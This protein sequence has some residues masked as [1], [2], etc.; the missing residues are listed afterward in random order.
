MQ[1]PQTLQQ[2]DSAGWHDDPID[3]ADGRHATSAGWTLKYVLR[4]PV[5]LDIVAAPD[6]AGW[7]SALTAVA[8]T[9]TPGL[10]GWVALLSNAGGERITVGNG[11]IT[12]NADLSTV[13]AGYDTRSTA[14]RALSDAESALA[15][16]KGSGGKIKKYEIAGRSMEFFAVA[17]ILQV[18]SYWKARVISEQNDESIANGQGDQRRL[19]VRFR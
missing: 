8:N 19:Y 5:A 3:L 17:D 13:A 11:Q 6:G 4:G 10:Y 14:Q 18:I 1:I 15:S 7:K 9:L 2:G 16:F 12:V